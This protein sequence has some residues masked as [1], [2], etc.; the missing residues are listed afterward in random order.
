MW[1]IISRDCRVLADSG[2]LMQ[3]TLLAH[4]RQTLGTLHP[5]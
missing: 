2:E 3:R 1:S 4:G 5:R